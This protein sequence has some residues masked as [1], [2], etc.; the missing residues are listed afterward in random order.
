MWPLYDNTGIDVRYNCEPIDWYLAA[1]TAG[2]N[3]PR[4]SK[5]M[6]SICSRKS[7]SRQPRRPA[8]TW[9]DRHARDQHGDRACHSEPRCQAVQ[10]AQALSRRSNGCRF[11]G[12]VAAAASPGS[13]VRR[14][15]RMR[16]RGRACAVPH[17]RSVQPVPA[18]QRSEPGDVRLRRAVRRRRGR[19]A[20]AQYRRRRALRPGPRILAIG[21]WCWPD[22]EH[23]MGW[24]I[25]DDGFG[26]VLSPELPALM[27]KA[28]APALHDFL[29]RN[30]FQLVGLQRFSVPPGRAQAARDGGRG[31]GARARA[32]R[33]FLGGVAPATATCR[34]RRR[35]SCWS[36]RC[37]QARAAGICWRPSVRAFPP[38]SSWPICN[39]H[40]VRRSAAGFL[41]VQRLAE[42]W[43]AQTQRGTASRGGR[44]RVWRH[45][46]SR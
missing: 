45:R 30:G 5:S 38:I 23:I 18:R 34:R 1:R 14:G 40:L 19:R 44:R 3:A 31:A 39:G 15:L 35:C 13:R 10:P 4:R 32:L 42:L 24:D 20:V 28:L 6:R 25:K 9:R 16:C 33:S 2:K 26:V 27:R 12:S 8:S 29:D 17:R 41:T 36:V 43:W 46:I 7:R 37:K 11:S 22:T 21:E